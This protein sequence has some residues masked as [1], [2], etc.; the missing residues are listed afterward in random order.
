ME[1]ES[2]GQR[3]EAR[4]EPGDEERGHDDRRAV[5]GPGGIDAEIRPAQIEPVALR[6]V[7][8][9]AV[10]GV[11]PGEG[12]VAR[13]PDVPQIVIAVDQ[14][15]AGEEEDQIERAPAGQ[16]ERNGG[17]AGGERVVLR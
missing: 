10:V 11:G 12:D 9:A 7:V 15:G 1:E 3:A 13:L 14:H 2:P 6:L 16:G 8:A 4:Q 5:Q 17:H